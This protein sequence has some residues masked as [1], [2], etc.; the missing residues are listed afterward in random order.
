M[1]TSLR[2]GSAAKRQYRVENMERPMLARRFTIVCLIVTLFGMM[3]AM[4]VAEASRRPHAWT[5]ET[6]TSC[7]VEPGLGCNSRAGR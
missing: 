4:L 2:T 3:L 7:L 5:V 6:A 1:N